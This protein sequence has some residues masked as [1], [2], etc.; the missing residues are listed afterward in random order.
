MPT[1][2]TEAR[3]AGRVHF[4]SRNAADLKQKLAEL[5]DRP[6]HGTAIHPHFNAS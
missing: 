5:R 6:A 3:P 4:K 2:P 1:T